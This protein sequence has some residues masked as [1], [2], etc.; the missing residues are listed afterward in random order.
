MIKLIHGGDRAGFETEYGKAPLDF[1]ANISPL[2]LP[3]GVREAAAKALSSAE[4]YPDPLCRELRAALSEHFGIPAEN[5]VCG[6]GA[7]DLIY[8]LSH[9]LR[10]KKAAVFV[11]GFV[12]YAL[13]LRES[14]CVITEI[15]LSERDFQLTEKQIAMI[16]S[17][18]EQLFLCNPNNPTGLLTERETLLSVLELCRERGMNLCVDECFLDFCE[19]AGEYSLVGELKDN[20]GLVILKAF[21]KTY[22]MAGFRL[23]YALCGSTGLAERLQSSGQPWPVSGIAQ[24]AGIDAL[25]ELDYVN[26]LSALITAERPRMAAALNKLGLRV[27][28][29]EANYLLFHSTD[30][31]LAEKLRRRGILIRDCANFTGLTAGWYRTAIRTAAENDILLKTMGELLHG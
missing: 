6:N 31:A 16:P 5:I 28:P 30:T 13:A 3:E 20:P 19:R 22:A 9:A 17:G 27:I 12:E 26:Q 7:S 4:F 2:G 14:G 15:P 11:P 8:R 10:P 29:G 24:A 21:T 25:C 1:S 18:C 23:G